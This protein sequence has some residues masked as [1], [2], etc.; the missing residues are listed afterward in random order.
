MVPDGLLRAISRA[1]RSETVWVAA[2][3][4]LTT[5]A[6]WRALVD[7]EQIQLERT[8]ALAAEGLKNAID[9]EIAVRVRPIESIAQ[10]SALR[11]GISRADWEDDAA[12]FVWS[13]AGYQAIEWVDPSFHVQW[14]VPPALEATGYSRQPQVL[15]AFRAARHQRI[16]RATST[17]DLSAG[18]RG[19]LVAVPVF[20][21]SQLAGFVTGSFRC[22]ELLH[23]ILDRATPEGFSAALFEG[24][25]EIYSR[26]RGASPASSELR[27]DKVFGIHGV[28]WRL[29]LWPTR[30]SLLQW[31]SSLPQLVLIAGLLISALVTLSVR[32]AITAHARSQALEQANRMLQTEMAERERIAQEVLF[33]NNTLRSVIDT[34][35]VAILGVLPD[36]AV[37]AWNR[38]AEAMFGWREDEVIGRALPIAGEAGPA[39]CNDRVQSG[40]PLNGFE[41]NFFAKNGVAVSAEVW[42]APQMGSQGLLLRFL[43]IVADV[44]QRKQLEQQVRDTYKLEAVGRLAAGVAHNFNNLLTIISGYSQLALDGLPVGD[45]LRAEI[46][47]VVKA[48]D[49]AARL[50]I[51]LLGFARSQP[52]RPQVV[53]LNLFIADLMDVLERIAGVRSELI[54]SLGPE[55][56]RLLIDPDQLEADSDD[57]GGQ[58]TRRHAGRRQDYPRDR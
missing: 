6:V 24:G 12:L 22:T 51:Q 57:S 3:A 20:R 19:F 49:R 55:L 25:R 35:P 1:A 23:S 14:S 30:Q 44:R 46:L 40:E 18:E 48:A 52:I 29:I 4:L 53:D 16:A 43:C 54:P 13:Y 9:A 34:S 47:E 38:A 7:R 32:L 33:A 56:G 26:P 42:I 41:C 27:V 58:R 17:Y 2:A 50:T 36:G 8:T 11:P 39:F 31:R 21:N 45:P 15:A 5:F 28:P 37:T 10:R